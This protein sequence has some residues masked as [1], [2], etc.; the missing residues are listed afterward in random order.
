MERTKNFFKC[1]ARNKL[2]EKV[3]CIW[4]EKNHTVDV[5]CAVCSR[6]VTEV[7]IAFYQCK[8]ASCKH[9]ECLECGVNTARQKLSE[10]KNSLG[11]IKV[12]ISPKETT[13]PE[14]QS[15]SATNSCNDTVASSG[16]NLN[17]TPSASS[18]SNSDSEL[19]E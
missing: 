14:P 15:I 9:T 16:E 11:D 12:P 5:F 18:S 7:S 2:Q 19:E 1:I 6:Q 8:E 3:C 13:I 10:S 17:S 4:C